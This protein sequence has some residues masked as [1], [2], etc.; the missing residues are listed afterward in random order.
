M[1]NREARRLTE[2]R[3]RVRRMIADI[4]IQSLHVSIWYNKVR[5]WFS[6][7]R[8]RLGPYWSYI[9]RPGQ[10][11]VYGR[12]SYNC[13]EQFRSESQI[14]TC[15]ASRELRS[16]QST[17]CLYCTN[18]A[19]HPWSHNFT[20]LSRYFYLL[21]SDLADLGLDGRLAPMKGFLT[22]LMLW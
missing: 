3:E 17:T 9:D 12:R 22:G 19:N 5:G 13:N 18:Q 10:Y 20:L 15:V 6:V 8:P 7:S 16:E 21:P 2:Q 1:W 11:I 14:E 4:F